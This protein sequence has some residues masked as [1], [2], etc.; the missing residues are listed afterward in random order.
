MLQNIPEEPSL[1]LSLYSLQHKLK[2]KVANR[3]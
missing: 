3:E 2:K 1:P